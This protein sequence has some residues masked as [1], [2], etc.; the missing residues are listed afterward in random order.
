MNGRFIFVDSVMLP[1]GRL[2]ETLSMSRYSYS[3]LPQAFHAN[4][5]GGSEDHPKID[6]PHA[7]IGDDACA[8]ARQKVSGTHKYKRLD[9]GAS[10]GL[11]VLA[12]P[13]FSKWL[14]IPVFSRYQQRKRKIKAKP[15]LMRQEAPGR[16]VV[17]DHR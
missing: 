6:L 16:I 4:L 3:T 10:T 9:R 17:W 1:K 11:V 15:E 14:V 12:K 8:S 2:R 5:A 7:T 13:K